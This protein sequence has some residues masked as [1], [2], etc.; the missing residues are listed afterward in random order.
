MR[1]TQQRKKKLF[2]HAR[3]ELGFF[4]KSELTGIISGPQTGARTSLT[5]YG[6]WPRHHER[7]G[8]LWR[9]WNGS[10]RW[11]DWRLWCS[12]WGV[13]LLLLV[14]PGRGVSRH[15][16]GAAG[17][18]LCH[19]RA[20]VCPHALREAMAAAAPQAAIFTPLQARAA[21]VIILWRTGDGGWEQGG[22]HSRPQKLDQKPRCCWSFDKKCT[23]MWNQMEFLSLPAEEAV[24]TELFSAFFSAHRY[25]IITNTNPLIPQSSVPI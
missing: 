4:L 14:Y 19:R 21:A 7:R 12:C 2:K 8:R 1:L 23:Q 24:A 9:I 25:F 13:R 10:F 22:H 3:I 6:V 5:C 17:V 16:R 20:G 11:V 15:G 18:F